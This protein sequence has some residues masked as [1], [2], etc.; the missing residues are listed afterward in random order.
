AM[1]RH[2]RLFFLLTLVTLGTSTVLLLAACGGSGGAD[3]K[4]QS[5]T[6]LVARVVAVGI[7]GAGPVAAVGKFLPGGPINDNAAFKAYTEGGKVLEAD[8]LLVGSTS[9]FGAPVATKEDM[10]GS[11]LSIDA[12]STD[13][14][15]V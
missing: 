2:R 13:V 9:N 4:D 14:L 8:R 10:P 1:S 3:K 5:S 11:L 6:A 15:K 7:P 12:K